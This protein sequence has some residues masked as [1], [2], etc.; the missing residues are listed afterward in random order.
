MNSNQTETRLSGSRKLLLNAC[1]L[2]FSLL[3]AAAGM[4]LGLRVWDS[5]RLRGVQPSSSVYPDEELVYRQNPAWSD[6]SRSGSQDEIRDKPAE[7]FRVLILGDSVAFDPFDASIA[8]LTEANLNSDPAVAPVEFLNSAVSGY[9]CYQEVQ[10]LKRYGLP[11]QPRLVGVIYVL[12]D[13]HELL[14]DLGRGELEFI[15]RSRNDLPRWMEWIR[16]RSRLVEFLRRNIKVVAY[17]AGWQLRGRPHFEERMDFGPAWQDRSW[18]MVK[19]QLGELVESAEE[20]GFGVFLAAVPYGEQ[21]TGEGPLL[22]AD[23]RLKP[24]RKLKEICR[25][26]SI[27]FLDLMPYLHIEAHFKSD[28]IHLKPAGRQRVADELATFLKENQLVPAAAE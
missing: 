24:Q 3:L 15:Y 26:L 28:L 11:F 25:S 8:G 4:E 20:H 17:R 14:H 1:L 27:P 16:A 12:N 18:P 22:D 21:L 5:L 7:G 13:N 2:A 9:T 23:I 19:E 6:F 10:W